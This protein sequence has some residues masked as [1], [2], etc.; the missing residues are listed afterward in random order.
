[1]HISDY[2]LYVNSSNAKYNVKSYNSWYY[3][4]RYKSYGNILSNMY[5]EGMKWSIH[6]SDII[7][8]L[9]HLMIMEESIT[10]VLWLCGCQL[11]KVNDIHI[12]A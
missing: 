4:Y 2:E 1:M 7:N 5:K 3:G 12:N 10:Q 9:W 11:N 6:L 8:L